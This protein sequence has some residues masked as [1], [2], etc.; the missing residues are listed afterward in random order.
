MKLLWVPHAPW[1]TPQRAR[2]LCEQLSERHEVHVVSWTAVSSLRDLLKPK[3]VIEA[4]APRSNSIRCANLV[5]HPVAQT[6]GALYSSWL[7]RMNER[8]LQRAVEVV[9]TAEGIDVVVIARPMPVPHLSVPLVVDFFDDNPPYWSHVRGRRDLAAEVLAQEAELALRADLVTAASLVL[10]EKVAEMGVSA[11]WL[12]NGFD[13]ARVRGGDRDA[14][15]KSLDIDSRETLVGYVGWFTESSGLESAVRSAATWPAGYSLVI[16]GQGPSIAPARRLADRLGAKNVRFLGQLADVRD[17]FAGIDVGLLLK[18]PNAF[19]HAASNIKL[20][21][22]LGAGKPVVSTRLRE[23]EK[24]ALPGVIFC[25]G[26][27]DAVWTAI[28]NLGS[29]APRLSTEHL[30][31]YAW[32]HIAGSFELLATELVSG[33]RDASA[34]RRSGLGV[35]MIP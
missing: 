10:T 9:A 1:S 34:A 14:F 35:G 6:P 17:F 29:G 22:Y 23:V 15:R 5:L 21:E 13:L 25:D 11:T 16:A 3:R 12:P 2:Y 4:A 8:R 33:S 24:Q 28:R 18:E 27:G 20:L 32:S 7:R 19:T 30:A 31:E 26:G